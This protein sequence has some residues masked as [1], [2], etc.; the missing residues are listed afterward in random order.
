MLASH[1]LC[2]QVNSSIPIVSVP[3]LAGAPSSPALLGQN[4][5]TRFFASAVYAVE[6]G[7]NN[8][9]NDHYWQNVPMWRNVCK[10]QFLQYRWQ[11]WIP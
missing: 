8:T 3:K 2:K 10:E 1:K 5:Y 7:V 11:V 4:Q 9:H 6:A